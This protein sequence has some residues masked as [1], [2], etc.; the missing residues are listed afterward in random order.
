MKHPDAIAPETSLAERFRLRAFT[1]IELL[2]VIAIIAILAALLLPSLQSARESARRSSCMNNLR[3][4]SL[5]CLNYSTDNNDW[6]PGPSNV[7][8]PNK[9]MW[10]FTGGST[11]G[12][13]ATLYVAGAGTNGT[14]FPKYSSSK[15][16]TYQNLYRCPSL[17][18]GRTAV[19]PSFGHS[20][21]MYFGGHGTSTNPSSWYGWLSS[22]YHNGFRR[23]PK[24][25]LIS[26]PAETALLMDTTFLGVPHPFVYYFS[27][28]SS[29]PAINH[30][31][32]G[33]L[34]ALGQNIVFDDG[35][36]EWIANP[37]SRTLRFT[38]GTV[39]NA[40]Y[41]AAP[42]EVRW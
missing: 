34:G 32:P 30:A 6:L 25:S 13:Y 5:M 42:G 17:Q 18:F 3:Q 29:F 36:G 37:A 11:G 10:F 1:L 35:H 9:D 38:G 31:T 40:S 12:V 4:I 26:D 39:N 7:S 22:N 14:W 2:V 24:I 41:P 33:G 23:T 15:N 8:C 20:S 19:F 27:D 21:Y 28:T 16:S